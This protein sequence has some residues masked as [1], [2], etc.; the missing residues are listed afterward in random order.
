MS[1][2]DMIFTFDGIPNHR[3]RFNIP[4]NKSKCNFSIIKLF[5]L[6]V[7]VYIYIY[8]QCGC[9]CDYVTNICVILRI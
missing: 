1:H 8:L 3:F 7:F 9:A 5:Y 2:N 6:I 4:L